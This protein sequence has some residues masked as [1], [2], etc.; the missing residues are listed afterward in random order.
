[1]KPSW[2]HPSHRCLSITTPSSPSVPAQHGTA[3]A[4]LGNLHGNQYPDEP[5]RGAWPALERTVRCSVAV[6]ADTFELCSRFSFRTLSLYITATIACRRVASSPYRDDRYS[7]GNTCW[8]VEK[9]GQMVDGPTL[10]TC[11][12]Y[13]RADD[14]MPEHIYSLSSPFTIQE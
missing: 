12:G 14:I 4:S 11:G 1:M 8:P 10:C 3:G 9:L 13:S 2:A 5:S 7:G 6:S